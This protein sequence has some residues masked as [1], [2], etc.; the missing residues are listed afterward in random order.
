MFNWLFK[1][2]RRGFEDGLAAREQDIAGL[3]EEIAWLR[4]QLALARKREF[5]ANDRADLA[6]DRL[7][8]IYGAR[9]ISAAYAHEEEARALRSAG[10]RDEL[11]EPDFGTPG[12]AFATP[13]DAL[14]G[15]TEPA[16][17]GAAGVLDA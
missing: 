6:A 13:E 14:I 10:A 11:T 3:R 5:E 17:D 12:S 8:A 16:P 4:E 15:P 1:G 2:Y 7:L 9:G